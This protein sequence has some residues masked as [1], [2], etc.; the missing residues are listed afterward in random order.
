MRARVAGKLEPWD[1]ESD[2]VSNSASKDAVRGGMPRT[3]NAQ[4]AAPRSGTQ[5]IERTLRLLRE[6]GTRSHSGWQLADLARGCE[7]DKGTVRRMLNCLVRERMVTRRAQDG[8]YLPGPLIYELSFGLP[9]YAAFQRAGQERVAALA[10][11]TRGVASLYLRSG[12][13]YV[14]IAQTVGSA[15]KGLGSV[16][17]GSRHP[18]M[19]VT[20]GHAILAAMKRDEA[21]RVIARNLASLERAGYGRIRAIKRVL[22]GSIKA[23]FGI[24]EGLLLPGINAFGVA[25]RGVDGQP[26]GALSVAGPGDRFPKSRAD[27][28]REMLDT[29]AGALAKRA[30]EMKLG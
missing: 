11:R 15:A 7:L 23:G 16:R 19:L 8:H 29:E 20:G 30:A 9:A 28:I 24:T 18:L 2:D 22:Q 25:I 26:F 6:I 14:C 1:G 4:T 17:V 10:A 5:S 13:D 12:D 21:R 27:E 3:L